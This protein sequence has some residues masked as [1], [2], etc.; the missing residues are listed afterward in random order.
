VQFDNPAA[1]REAK[2]TA[3]AGLTV[4]KAQLLKRLHE[5]SVRKALRGAR[6]ERCGGP[7]LKSF[8]WSA[9]LMPGPLSLRV[10]GTTQGTA[11]RG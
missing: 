2:S 5:K 7:T 11:R 10:H 4:A 8:A 3:A 6:R 9:A 1:D